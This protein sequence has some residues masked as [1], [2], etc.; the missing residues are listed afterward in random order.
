ME[1]GIRLGLLDRFRKSERVKKFRLKYKDNP[2]LGEFLS[3][4]EIMG[5]TEKEFLEDPEKAVAKSKDLSTDE[6][7]ALLNIVCEDKV[8]LRKQPLDVATNLT[9][10]A[11]SFFLVN[12]LHRITIQGNTL[13]AFISRTGTL[14]GNRVERIL[15]LSATLQA[16]N[17]ESMRN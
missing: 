6:C 2:T 8:N 13:N 17:H 11:V 3:V 7:Q 9:A 14:Y 4:L 16:M 5:L 12:A 10:V 1:E 15:G